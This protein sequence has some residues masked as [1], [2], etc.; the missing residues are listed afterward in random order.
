VSFSLSASPVHFQLIIL[1]HVVSTD[2]SSSQLFRAGFVWQRSVNLVIVQC[3]L[4]SL[5]LSLRN[6]LYHP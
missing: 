2:D 6:Q 1:S 5:R 3:S 4:S